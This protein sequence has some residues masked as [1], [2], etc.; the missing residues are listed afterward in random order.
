[1]GGVWAPYLHSLRCHRG[2]F[3]TSD[4]VR[5]PSRQLE[6]YSNVKWV[7]IEHLVLFKVQYFVEWVSPKSSNVDFISQYYVPVK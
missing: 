5:I 6:L 4:M 7:E 1:M 3:Y 2:S